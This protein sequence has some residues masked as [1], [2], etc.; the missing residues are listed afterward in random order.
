MLQNIVGILSTIPT[1]SKTVDLISDDN[2][3]EA[4][5]SEEFNMGAMLET[6]KNGL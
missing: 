5:A 4:I 6:V 2:E 1:R 3:I